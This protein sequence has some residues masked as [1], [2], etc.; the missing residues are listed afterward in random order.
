MALAEYLVESC[1]H[2]YNRNPT[3]AAKRRHCEP[4]RRGERLSLRVI[5]WNGESA[6]VTGVYC[7][8]DTNNF[9]DLIVLA[10]G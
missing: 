7:P 6:N 5:D 1:E 10:E 2:V 3:R 4:G 8:A 9:E